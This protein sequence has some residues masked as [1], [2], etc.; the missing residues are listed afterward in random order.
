MDSAKTSVTWIMTGIF[1]QVQEQRAAAQQAIVDLEREK[2]DRRRDLMAFQ[3]RLSQ[4]QMMMSALRGDA[5]CATAR[6]DAVQEMLEEC[7]RA[8]QEV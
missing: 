4:D 7:E 6:G 5:E 8:R 3:A 2:G 1:E